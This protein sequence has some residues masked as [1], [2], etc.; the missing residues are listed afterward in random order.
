MT[1]GIYRNAASTKRSESFISKVAESFIGKAVFFGIVAGL[2]YCIAVSLYLI[3][4]SIASIIGVTIGIWLTLAIVIALAGLIS[5][6]IMAVRNIYEKMHTSTGVLW[7]LPGGISGGWVLFFW[8]WLFVFFLIGALAAWC[9]HYWLVAVVMTVIAIVL[10]FPVINA[11][12][13]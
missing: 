9:G 2:I 13:K 7:I 8:L 3:S 5:W 12:R 10:V 6:F 11:W 4:T 1:Y